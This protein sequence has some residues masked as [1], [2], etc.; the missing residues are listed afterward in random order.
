MRRDW[1]RSPCRLVGRDAGVVELV[2]EL[3]GERAGAGEDE[4]LA[5]AGGELLDDRALVALLDEQ[6]AVVDRGGGLVFTGDLVHGRVD[7]ELVDERGDTLVEG[8][9]EEQ[10]LA[11]LLG[12]AAGCAAPARGSRGRTC[13]RPRRAP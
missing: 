1:L 2:G 13:G 7:E 4:G 10:L 9:R 6:H 11:A 12:L 3:L 8:R 5:G